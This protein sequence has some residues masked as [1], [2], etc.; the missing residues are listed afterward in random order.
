MF[1]SF[2]VLA[3]PLKPLEHFIDEQNFKI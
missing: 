3:R 2:P 1:G